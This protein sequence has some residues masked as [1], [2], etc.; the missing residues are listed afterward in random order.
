MLVAPPST[1]STNS[2]STFF[3]SP[4]LFVTPPS[5]ISDGVAISLT[6]QVKGKAVSAFV[7]DVTGVAEDGF[8]SLL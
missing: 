2:S 4:P 3:S 5:L 1:S 6:V 8:A 7:T